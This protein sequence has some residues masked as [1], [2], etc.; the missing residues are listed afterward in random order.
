MTPAPSLL[1]EL[2]RILEL[3]RRATKGPWTPEFRLGGWTITELKGGTN[4]D[5]NAALVVA[6]RNLA[7][8]FLPV[9]LSALRVVEAAKHMPWH[10][11]APSGEEVALREA[12]ANHHAL[13][14]Q[15][16]LAADTAKP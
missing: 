4:G 9:M 2:A 1:E 11:N 16:R 8:R 13:V 7:P 14:A 3:E 10:P 12:L 6:L 15:D 5:A